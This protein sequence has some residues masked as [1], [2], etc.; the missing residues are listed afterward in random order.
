MAYDD[1]LISSLNQQVKQEIL[2]RYFRERRIIE[3]EI[4]LLL[5]EASSFH[6][7]V[8]FWEAHRAR[9]GRALLSPEAR[10]EFFELAG[11]RPPREE[12]VDNVPWAVP[13]R[14]PR[15][16]T[17]A[18]RYRDLVGQLYRDLYD[19]GQE[20]LAERERVLELLE[21]V[22]R[23]IKHFENTHDFLSLT[24]YLRTLDPQEIE[25][26]K[27]L[28]VNFT[29]RESEVSAEALSFRPVAEARLE[30][31]SEAW[32]MRTPKEVLDRAKGLLKNVFG[33]QRD[34]AARLF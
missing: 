27:F 31:E 7:G 14:R 21:E 23:D 9:L 15:G 8:A 5:E 1:D 19:M 20:L 13:L 28:G 22:N 12:R 16:W 34:Q 4:G 18:G 26:R 10:A 17:M 30:L 33:Q 24:A 2:D 3:E 11:V 6:G 29:A 32:L 25:R